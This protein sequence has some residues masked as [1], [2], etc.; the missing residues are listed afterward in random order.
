MVL[1]RLN[2]D[3]NIDMFL[4]FKLSEYFTNILSYSKYISIF[5]QKKIIYPIFSSIITINI[6][7][8]QSYDKLKFVK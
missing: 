8:K 7:N 3:N 2:I 1:I 4:S 5:F 6:S